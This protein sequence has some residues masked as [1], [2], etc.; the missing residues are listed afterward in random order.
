MQE[1]LIIVLYIR[2]VFRNSCG[3]KEKR[4]FRDMGCLIIFLRQVLS[5]QIFSI[6]K[7]SPCHTLKIYVL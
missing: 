1:K 7:N 5:A 2:I 4:K 3:Q 6:C